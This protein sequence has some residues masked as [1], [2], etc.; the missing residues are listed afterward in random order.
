M[1]F[2]DDDVQALRQELRSVNERL[3]MIAHALAVAGDSAQRLTTLRHGLEAVEVY[4]PDW[5]EG[6]DFNVEALKTLV[7]VAL[8]RSADGE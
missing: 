1:S 6:V 5:T 3:E 2:Q 7:R 8:A 4:E